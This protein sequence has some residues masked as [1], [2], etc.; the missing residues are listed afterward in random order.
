MPK[1]PVAGRRPRRNERPPP[2]KLPNVVEGHLA[3]ICRDLALETKRMRQLQEHADQ[4]R[5]IIRQ[6]AAHPRRGRRATELIVEDD[7][8]E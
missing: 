4:L 5:E 3:E 8:Q 1:S 6:W 2:A 7:A